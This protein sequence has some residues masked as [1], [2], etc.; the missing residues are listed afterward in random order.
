M[1]A[2]A[3]ALPQVGATMAVFA[4]SAT[5]PVLALRHLSRYIGTNRRGRLLT[6]WRHGKM[7]PGAAA[8]AVGLLVLTG[9]D[10]SLEGFLVA[11]S[12]SWLTRLTTSF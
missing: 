6:L 10:T 11:V 9:L 3:R 7:A 4:A 12:P 5:L 1:A 8:R 2:R